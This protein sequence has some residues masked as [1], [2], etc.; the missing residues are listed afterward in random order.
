[1]CRMINKVHNMWNFVGGLKMRFSLNRVASFV[2][3]NSDPAQCAQCGVKTNVLYY[4]W[5]DDGLCT[6]CDQRGEEQYIADCE[7][8][9]GVNRLIELRHKKGE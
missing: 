1:M 8:E 9:R 5:H 3:W 6:N 2:H 7:I 4:T